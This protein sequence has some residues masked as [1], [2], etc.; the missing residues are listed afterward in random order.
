MPDLYFSYATIHSNAKG[1][2]LYQQL[3][4]L[5]TG[6][7]EDYQKAIALLYDDQIPELNSC[8]WNTRFLGTKW[9][10]I[11][12]DDEDLM[13]ESTWG[14]P[15]EFFTQLYHKL[16]QI[17]PYSRIRLSFNGNDFGVAHWAYGRQH[18]FRISRAEVAANLGIDQGRH[19][20]EELFD[21]EVYKACNR[22]E[23]WVPWKEWAAD[24]IW[25]VLLRNGDSQRLQSKQ[26]KT[27]VMIGPWTVVL[28]TPISRVPAWSSDGKAS[29][30]QRCLV[31][32]RETID[33]FQIEFEYIDQ[34]AFDADDFFDYRYDGPSTKQSNEAPQDIQSLC[35]HPNVWKLFQELA[36][37]CPGPELP[38]PPKPKAKGGQEKPIPETV[39][40]PI[41]S[42][43]N[44]LELMYQENLL[45]VKTKAVLQS[46]A[47]GTAY[48]MAG[49]WAVEQKAELL[50]EWLFERDDVLEVY[51]SNEDL[52]ARLSLY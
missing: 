48:L 31:Q 36:L 39:E 6:N 4:D 27:S 43:Y 51:I 9:M 49:Q 52:A 35:F 23:R 18:V 44:F 17:H 10:S 14:V 7:Q 41:A 22:F 5:L 33:H 12:W 21:W 37:P 3:G 42:A 11:S 2:A 26:E 45:E 50:S 13:C 40:P 16:W 47:E 20:F 32:T 34:N 1:K 38:P 24:E 8:N 30:F 15:W 19:D 28:E 29:I 25:N 46:L